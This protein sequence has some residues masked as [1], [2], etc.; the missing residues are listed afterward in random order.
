[1]GCCWGPPL[2]EGCDHSHKWG[3]TTPN[4]PWSYVSG[5][6]HSLSL[7]LAFVPPPSV[8]RMF[9]GGQSEWVLAYFSPRAWWGRRIWDCREKLET[10][11]RSHRPGS[12]LTPPKAML[13]RLEGTLPPPTPTIRQ[14]EGPPYYLRFAT[15]QVPTEVRYKRRISLFML[16]RATAPQGFLLRYI[17][18]SN[19]MEAAPPWG[20]LQKKHSQAVVRAFTTACTTDKAFRR[21]F[22]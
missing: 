4:F 13:R 18:P 19:A 16:F 20:Q 12:T 2:W 5:T 6:S 1:M 11:T 15:S 10:P 8:V 14:P 9:I 21:S 3:S 17:I 22:I 7:P